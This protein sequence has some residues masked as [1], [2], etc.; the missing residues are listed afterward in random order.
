MTVF[1][2]YLETI[3][4]EVQRERLVEILQWIEKNYP[5]LERAFK[6]NQPMYTEHGTFIIGFSVATKH[7][8]VAPE[9]IEPFLKSIEKEGYSYGKKLMRIK[10]QEPIPYTLLAEMISYNQQ[11]KK[12]CSTFWR[13]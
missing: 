12:D 10:E 7:I 2:A 1:D 9:N 5:T 11:T 3:P 13:R 6:W 8:S 4:S